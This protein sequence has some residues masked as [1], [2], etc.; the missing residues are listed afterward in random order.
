MYA[1]MLLTTIPEHDTLYLIDWEDV[2]GNSQ[3]RENICRNSELGLKI[4]LPG[5]RS[6]KAMSTKRAAP[7]RPA[8]LQARQKELQRIVCGGSM[9]PERVQLRQSKNWHGNEGMWLL[10]TVSPRI[11][12]TVSSDPVGVLSLPKIPSLFFTRVYVQLPDHDKL[13]QMWACS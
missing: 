13:S 5:P 11:R 12:D 6:P 3:N 1:K 2:K 4:R 10:T 9:P 7:I 8:W